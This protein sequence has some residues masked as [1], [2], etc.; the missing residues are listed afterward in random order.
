MKYRLFIRRNPLFFCGTCFSLF[1]NKQAKACS[2]MIFYSATPGLTAGK[3]RSGAATSGF[4]RVQRYAAMKVLTIPANRT[5]FQ[6]FVVCNTQ[7]ISA[8]D[9]KPAQFDEAFIK[10]ATAPPDRPPI[11]TAED[12]AAPRYKSM[13]PAATAINNAPARGRGERTP[14]DI[15][16][17]VRSK[18]E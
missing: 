10:P 4:T 7:P 9:A 18:P 5:V 2:T 14:S 15:S 3:R 1:V 16:I 17:P 12:H 13:V 11:S 6:L 8:G